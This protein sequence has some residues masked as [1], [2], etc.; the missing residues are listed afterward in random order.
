MI[1]EHQHVDVSVG[2]DVGKSD[3]HAVALDRAGTV[4]Y[5]RAVPNDEAK[6]WAILADLPTHGLVLVVVDQ[7]AA[8]GAGVS[9]GLCS[10]GY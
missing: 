4:P 1:P 10:G 9:D 2:L 3:H 8:I 5:D 7:P 6:L